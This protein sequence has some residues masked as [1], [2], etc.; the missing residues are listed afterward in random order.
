MWTGQQEESY[1]SNNRN[2]AVVPQQELHQNEVKKILTGLH[3]SLPVTSF[4]SAT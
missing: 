2:T 4:W 1:I 3:R